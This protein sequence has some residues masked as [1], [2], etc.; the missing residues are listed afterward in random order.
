LTASDVPFRLS[1]FQLRCLLFPVSSSA[2]FNCVRMY[3]PKENFNPLD[4]R[5]FHAR[6]ISKPYFYRGLPSEIRQPLVQ[7]SHHIK[8]TESIHYNSIGFIT[9]FGFRLPLRHFGSFNLHYPAM[10]A[11]ADCNRLEVRGAYWRSFKALPYL[12]I[13]SSKKLFS[14]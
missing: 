14:L 2:A 7:H 11:L 4:K 10:V 12:F 8:T 13:L 5:Y 6:L 3:S 1:L 9:P